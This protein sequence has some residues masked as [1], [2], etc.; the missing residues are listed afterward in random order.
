M[1]MTTENETLT[2]D[3]YE[4]QIERLNNELD[5]ERGRADDLRETLYDLV[6]R[7]DCEWKRGTPL[8]PKGQAD[9]GWDEKYPI[10][11]KNAREL[12]LGTEYREAL[13]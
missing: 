2:P 5:D 13:K 4:A 8:I 6:L 3:Q 10:E 12:L 11:L 1:N 9:G 7:I